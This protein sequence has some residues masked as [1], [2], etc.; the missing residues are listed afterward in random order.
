MKSQN[1]FI[2]S[3]PVHLLPFS[4][5]AFSPTML[6]LLETL[7]ELLLWNIFQCYRHIFQCLQ[8]Y[9]VRLYFWK[10]PQVIRSQIRGSGWVFRFSNRFLGQKLFHCELEH[11]HDGESNSWAKIQASFYVHLHVTASIFPCNKLD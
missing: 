1:D 7:L 6:T 5:Y 8:Y 10:Q 9:Q 2:A 3:I 4:S 11:S